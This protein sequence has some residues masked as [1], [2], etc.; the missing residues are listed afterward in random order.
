MHAAVTSPRLVRVL[1]A[2]ARQASNDEPDVRFGDRTE[3]DLQA[4]DRESRIAHRGERGAWA[5]G[6][7]RAA[8]ANGGAA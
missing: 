3:A 6:L 5:T 4:I 7:G 1:G 8:A 2:D